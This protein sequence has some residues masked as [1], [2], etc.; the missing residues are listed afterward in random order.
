M[1]MPEGMYV[2]ILLLAFPFSWQAD[3]HGVLL[4]CATEPEA[5]L[6][7]AH[8]CDPALPGCLL[9]TPVCCRMPADAWCCC[10]QLDWF[11][12]YLRA[13]DERGFEGSFR[14]FMDLQVRTCW[15]HLG[16]ACAALATA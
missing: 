13:Q 14:M 3:V 16:D 6:P 1:W 10:L 11:E 15:W 8:C 12:V 2:M 4:D 9:L 7:A 5:L